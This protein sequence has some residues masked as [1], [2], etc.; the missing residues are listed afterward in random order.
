MANLLA[1]II[2][3]RFF[4]IL[5]VIFT[6]LTCISAAYAA[7]NINLVEVRHIMLIM[8]VPSFIFFL[9]ETLAEMSVYGLTKGESP[10]LKQKLN[11]LKLIILVIEFI[12]LTSLSV[13]S[14]FNK[15]SKIKVLRLVHLVDLEYQICWEMKILLN[16]IS[17]IGPIFIIIRFIPFVTYAFFT[18]L[19]TNSYQNFGYYCESAYDIE[20]VST[21]QDCFMYGG[22]WVSLPLAYHNTWDSFFIGT[23]IAT[24]EGWSTLMT[25]AMDFDEVGKVPSFNA[26]QNIQI[27]FIVFF[28]IGNFINMNN[29]INI[30]WLNFS[31]LRQI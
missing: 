13:N 16:S 2:F 8:N 10:Y 3:H 31:Q 15:I 27:F 28:F 12:G 22:D 9:L 5:K 4:R 7:P 17:K 20:K 14:I 19:M 29:Y 18:L 25:D 23:Y 30:I 6:F 26:N 1:K 11:I 21:K 24:M